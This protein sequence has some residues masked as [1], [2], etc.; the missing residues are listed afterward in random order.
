MMGA[1]GGAA[2]GA[3]GQQDFGAAFKSEKQ[4]Y[5]L[6]SYKHHLEDVEEALI[7]KW[8]ESKTSWAN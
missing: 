5:E 4:N 3:P 1:Q 7:L 2:G 8:K 6:L